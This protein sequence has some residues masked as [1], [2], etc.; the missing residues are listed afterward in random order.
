MSTWEYLLVSLPT[1]EP[2]K[3]AQGD[4]AA[5]AMLNREGA[6]GWEAV[7]MTALG[8]GNFAVLL[9]RLAMPDRSLRVHEP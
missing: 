9:K 5:V 1:F 8:D 7:G 2:A 4:S 3:A 6:K